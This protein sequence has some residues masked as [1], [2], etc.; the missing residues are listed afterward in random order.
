[1]QLL[2]R[3]GRFR[4]GRQI[5]DTAS[6]TL[7]GASLKGFLLALL[8]LELVGGA[9][10]ACRQS[11]RPHP[12]PQAQTQTQTGQLSAATAIP[13][14]PITRPTP[15]ESLP[16]PEAPQI[17]GKLLMA[18]EGSLWRWESGRLER[19]TNGERFEDPAWSPD[20]RLIAAT[21]VG[22]NH[23]D[24]V[25]LDEHGVLASQLTRNWSS[26]SVRESNW[27]RHPAWSPDGS[28]IAYCSDATTTD[29]ALW[30]MD[31]DGRNPRMVVQP[32]GNGGNDWPAWS[33]NG[34]YIAFSAFVSPVSQ[35]YVVE[36]K[37]GEIKQLT[38][39]SGG[40]YAPAWSPDGK[41]IAYV[42]RNGAKDDIWVIGA[43]GT[44]AIPLTQSGV[45]AS[46]TWSPD[47]QH[48]AYVTLF[49]GGFDVEAA[50]LEFDARGASKVAQTWRLTREAQLEAPAGLS[51]TR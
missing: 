34:L 23:S 29:L 42:A 12:E 35:I 38:D 2:G 14:P 13:A 28:T 20:G 51:W 43:D 45:S 5:K 11:D 4:H 6:I 1:M 32:L 22:D 21:L 46:P 27:A 36:A 10:V 7:K 9:L 3:Q 15:F 16:A 8:C 26:V 48:L 17:D 25:L 31:A 37:S 33:P 47:G 24:V 41:R 18:R 19:I 30:V 44:G 39:Q 40:A 49:G 50:R